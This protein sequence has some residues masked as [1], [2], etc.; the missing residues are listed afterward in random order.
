MRLVAIL[1]V[2]V[3]ALG[4]PAESRQSK[5]K[6][7]Q[8]FARDGVMWALSWDA[9]TQ[10][11]VGRNVPIH[12]AY[13]SDAQQCADTAEEFIKP[14][15]IQQ[16]RNWVNVIVC[17]DTGHGE[18]EVQVSKDEKV[19][20]CKRYWGI[21]CETHVKAAE[22]IGKIS[23]ETNFTIPLSWYLDTTG[24]EIGKKG[25]AVLSG[26]EIG[27]GMEKAMAVCTGDRIS[28]PEWMGYMKARKDVKEGIE[29]GEWKRAMTGCNILRKAKTKLLEAEG[30]EA[31]N[32]L[33][34]KG[35]ELLKEAQD[36][37]ATDK[38]KA[39]KMLTM[40]SND[41]KPLMCSGRAADMLKSLK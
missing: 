33:S 29:K 1:S 37:V 38:E 9:A 5:D 36:L 15:Y 40:L 21:A 4:A 3:L 13:H 2:V 24:R 28:Y 34:E 16:S 31:M 6:N 26:S 22:C 10:E 30:K 35:D 14:Q 27:K 23:K 32:K 25:G 11:A 8:A 18:E 12:V 19:K 7:N 17:K 41:F 20:R 39:K